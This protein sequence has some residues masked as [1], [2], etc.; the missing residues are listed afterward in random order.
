M[1][2]CEKYWH[3][4]WYCKNEETNSMRREIIEEAHPSFK[5]LQDG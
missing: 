1:D 5:Q 2:Y 3:A 4:S